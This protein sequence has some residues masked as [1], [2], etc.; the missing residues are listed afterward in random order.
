MNAAG[1]SVPRLRA[2]ASDR[3]AHVALAL[4]ILFLLS[5]LAAPL[6]PFGHCDVTFIF[7]QR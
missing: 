4:V 6:L 5:F 7:G 3:V 1:A 2:T